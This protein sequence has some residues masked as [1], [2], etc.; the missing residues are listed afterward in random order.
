MLP[1]NFCTF[2]PSCFIG[3]DFLEIE[4]SEKRIACGSHVYN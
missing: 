1:A 2:D 3:K 4:Q